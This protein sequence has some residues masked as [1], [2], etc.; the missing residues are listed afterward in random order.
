MKARF[1]GAQ[2]PQKEEPKEDKK[3]HDK[4]KKHIEGLAVK[5]SKRDKEKSKQWECCMMSMIRK[6]RLI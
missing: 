6:I 2:E 4:E 3:H 5:H 1:G